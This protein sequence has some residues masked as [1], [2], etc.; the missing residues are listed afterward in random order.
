[1]KLQ[2]L[3][4]SIE[5]IAMSFDGIKDFDYG[6]DYL[7]ATGK[8]KDYP[9]VFLEIPYGLDYQLKNKQKTVQFS[10]LVLFNSNVDDIKG[11]HETISEAENIA[12][13]MITKMQNEIS[14]FKIESANAVSVREF[15]DDNANGIRIDIKG[16]TPR[17]KCL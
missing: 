10:L 14:E 6:E 13:L 15:S 3:K 12:D 9:L 2:D 5:T 7:L 1:M 8:G 4:D 16:L 11:D 17:S